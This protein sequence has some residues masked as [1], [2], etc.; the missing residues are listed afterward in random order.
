MKYRYLFI[1]LFVFLVG[2]EKILGPDPDNTPENNF[3]IF[4]KD[5]NLYYAQ[6]QIR[7]ID[8][9]SVY[10][11]TRPQISPQTTDRQL[12]NILSN[13]VLRLNDMHTSLY[14][15]FG[16]INVYLNSLLRTYPSSKF[17]NPGK[18]TT[19]RNY[20]SSVLYFGKYKDDNIGY[21]NINT[22]S[23]GGDN[24]TLLDDRYLVIDDILQQFKDTKG[25]LIDVRGNGGGNEFNAE[26]VADRFAD[27]KR[28]F[29]KFC[30]K[31]GP[32]KNDFSE[33]IS[34]YIE[35]KGAYQYNKPVVVLTSRATCSAAEYFVMAMKVLPQVTTVGDTTS[36]GIG[37]PIFRELPNGWTYRLSTGIGATTD[38]YIIEGKGIP[39]DIPVLTTVADSINGIDRI[40]EKGIEIIENSK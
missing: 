13:I 12:F 11:V 38:G 17:I 10:T 16:D 25:L 26:T 29:A 2:C 35:P 24:I 27:Q 33:W 14:S 21:I 22:F 1:F 40:V 6:F 39:P 30:M 8:W 19:N 37:Y 9:D 31:N 7:H 5:F 3:E 15:P 20:Q 34:R 23:V 32:G 18:Y 4:W 36:G 28:F